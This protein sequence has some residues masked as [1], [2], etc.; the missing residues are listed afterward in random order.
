MTTRTATV[1]GACRPAVPAAMEPTKSGLIA[2]SLGAAFLAALF[3]AALSVSFFAQ[4][5]AAADL[6]YEPAEYERNGSPYDD[7]RYR[8]IYGHKES[9]VTRYK[10]D[11]YD[12]DYRGRSSRTYSYSST[13]RSHRHDDGR[14]CNRDHDTGYPARRRSYSSR[15][16]HKSVIRQRLKDDGW[17]GFKLVR[18]ARDYAVLKARFRDGGR[19]R[20]RYDSGLY[21]LRVDRCTGDVLRARL[22]D[23]S[24]R[25]DDRYAYRN[26]GRYRGF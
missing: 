3:L 20:R 24:Y 12:D 26:G 4:S 25:R 23:R 16:L 13:Y 10:S 21:R 8:A 11:K 18:K 2:A 17:Y 7:P 19:Y 9:Q 1:S 15:C 22:I 6:Y 5:A 14:L